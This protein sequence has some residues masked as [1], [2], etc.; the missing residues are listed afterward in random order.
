MGAGRTWES[1]NPNKAESLSGV[2]EIA[3][4]DAAKYAVIPNQPRDGGHVGGDDEK[5]ENL[6]SG[7]LGG[8]G[9]VP[10]RPRG[11][12]I[13]SATTLSNLHVP[14]EFPKPTPPIAKS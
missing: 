9:N 8:D 2:P 1:N 3:T 5:V 7:S 10:E 12:R 6:G 14:G 13:D 11:A 4:V